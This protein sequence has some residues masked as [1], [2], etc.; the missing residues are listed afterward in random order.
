[1]FA[2]LWSGYSQ[3]G[4]SPFNKECFRSNV[5]DL[6]TGLLGPYQEIRSPTFSVRLELA[7]AVRKSEGFVFPSMDR[8]TRLVNRLLHGI[9]I[10]QT[11]TTSLQNLH[12][13]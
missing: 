11:K 12:I 4:L 3:M 13:V 2:R 1:M 7:R 6:L 8:V 5:N 9:I 10:F